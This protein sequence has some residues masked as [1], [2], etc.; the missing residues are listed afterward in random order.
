MLLLKGL[1]CP[2][3][4]FLHIFLH[5][6]CCHLLK[7][8]V[9]LAMQKGTTTTGLLA[10]LVVFVPLA[11]FSSSPLRGSDTTT[12]TSARNATASVNSSLRR[13]EPQRRPYAPFLG[14]LHGQLWVPDSRR[15][16][17]FFNNVTTSRCARTS[18]RYWRRFP[19]CSLGRWCAV[20]AAGKWRRRLMAGH[21]ESLT[22]LFLSKAKSVASSGCGQDD[23]SLRTAKRSAPNALMK[24]L[25]L[26][27]KDGFLALVNGC[28]IAPPP[29]PFDTLAL[30]RAAARGKPILFSGDSIIRQVF[31]RLGTTY[32]GPTSAPTHHRSTLT[33]CT[34]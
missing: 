26:S 19:E 11:Y 2:L 21:L 28:P 13:G 16:L 22:G 18:P 3:F 12:P 31:H 9:A 25:L 33:L 34:L 24:E 23:L 6:L 8:E 5:V 1:S 15:C 7:A 32:V 29:S 4:I 17:V 30:L 10:L 20:W 14:P 27:R